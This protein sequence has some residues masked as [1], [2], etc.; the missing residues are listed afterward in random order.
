MSAA[1]MAA[2]I[3]INSQV[4]NI[5]QLELAIRATIEHKLRRSIKAVGPTGIGKSEVVH[6]IAASYKMKVIDV[7]LLLWSLTDLKGIPYPDDTQTYT[8]WLINDILPRV[9]RDGEYGILLLEEL[10]D[11]PKAVRAAAYQLTLDRKLG[12]YELPDGWIIIAT[13]N[14][15][16]DGGA[17][18]SPLI[19]LNDRFE[20]HEVEPDF[21]TWRDYAIKVGYNPTVVSYLSANQI[22]LYTYDPAATAEVVFATPRSWV[23]VCDLLNVGLNGEVLRIKAQANVGSVQATK[24]LEY[25]K[26]VSLLP[27]IDMVIN[28]QYDEAAAASFMRALDVYYLLIQNLIHAVGT[29]FRNEGEKWRSYT[30]NSVN[31]VGHISGFPL[32]LKKSYVDQLCEVNKDIEKHVYNDSRSQQMTKL[33]QELD[34]IKV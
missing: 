15:E 2:D 32:E 14:R 3:P 30:D 26:N 29:E 31:F 17:Y 10:D 33:L 8:R 9:E 5:R 1:N 34:Y 24:F 25:L 16:Q 13:S 23:A 18:T 21:P 6:Q 4:I 20:I 27:N 22:A 12:S 28:G 19:P 7:R 11:A